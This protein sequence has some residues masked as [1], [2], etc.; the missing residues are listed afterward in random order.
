MR[1]RPTIAIA[2]G[3][4]LTASLA[5]VGAGNSAQSIANALSRQAGEMAN[6][7]AADAVTIRFASQEGWASRHAMLSPVGDL[8][9][10]T[11]ADIATAIATIPGVGGVHWTD[12]TMLAEAGEIPFASMQCQ[13]DVQA[14]LEARTIRFEESSSALAAGGTELLDEVAAALRP[15]VGAIIAVNGHTDNSGDEPANIVLSQRR[16]ATIERG[17]VARGI[18]EENLRTQGFG[19]AQPVEGLDSA[20]PANR[21]IEFSVVAKVPLRPTPVDTPGAR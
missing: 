8:D 16:A 11:R 18:P 10:G 13:D 17:L 5:F 19:S 3:A 12:G 9:E 4:L 20:D 1:I 2:A 15:C 6:S 14:I 21:R 7:V